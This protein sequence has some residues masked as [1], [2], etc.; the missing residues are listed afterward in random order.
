MG[1][2]RLR[3]S[4]RTRILPITSAIF[5]TSPDARLTRSKMLYSCVLGPPSSGGEFGYRCNALIAEKSLVGCLESPARLLLYSLP[6]SRLSV[7]VQACMNFAFCGCEAFQEIG[8][9]LRA[10]LCFLVIEGTKL[11]ADESRQFESVSGR[12]YLCH[13]PRSDP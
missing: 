1:W 11:P 4:P 3:G 10:R 5:T 12:R 2:I 9:S 13:W 8:Y 6:C 7:I